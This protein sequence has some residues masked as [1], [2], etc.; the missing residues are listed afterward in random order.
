MTGVISIFVATIVTVPLL[1]YVIVFII[2]KQLTKNHRRSVHLAIDVTTFLLIVSVHYLILT[3]WERSLL[4]L[5]IIFIILVAIVFVVFY[6]KT[7]D[8][9]DIPK[10]LRGF[11]RVNFLIFLLAYVVL[12]MFG[13][14]QRVFYVILHI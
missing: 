11:W 2:S 10:I 3:I 7:K 1:G 8:E 9:M 4:W 13:V 5:M 14:I 6:W 12:I